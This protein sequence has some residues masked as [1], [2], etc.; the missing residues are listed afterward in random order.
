MARRQRKAGVYGPYEHGLRWRVHVVDERGETTCSSFATQEEAAKVVRLSKKELALAA[1][2]TLLEAIEEYEMFLRRKEHKKYAET[3]RRLHLFFS[4]LERPVAT[5]RPKECDALYKSLT[6]KISDRT[7]KPFAVASHQ[8]TLVDAKTFGKWCVEK[9]WH[10]TSPVEQVRPVGKRNRGKP[11]LRVDEA[12]KWIEA[13]I[14]FANEGE[15]GAVAAMISLLMGMRCSEIVS[16]DVRDLDD[17]GKL[18][19]ITKSKTDAG[20]VTWKSPHCCSRTS[21]RSQ[22]TRSRPIA[23]SVITGGIGRENGWSASATKRA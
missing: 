20:G 5:L 4:D 7:G 6:E 15:D 23:S 14:G 3:I 19:W 10:R 22:R 21:F 2:A 1:S 8:N 9:Q 16:R 13:A 11:Q 18:L 17:D 12:R